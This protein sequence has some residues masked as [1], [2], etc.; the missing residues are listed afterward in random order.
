MFEVTELITEMNKSEDKKIFCYVAIF[1]N[2]LLCWNTDHHWLCERHG[3]VFRTITI[4]IYVLSI[5]KWKS[6]SR[7]LHNVI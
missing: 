3:G 7:M 2:Q 4:V 1:E 5:E 6:F